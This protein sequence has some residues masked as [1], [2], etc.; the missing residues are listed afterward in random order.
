MKITFFSNFLNHHQTPFCDEMRKQLG[1]NFIFVSTEET[2]ED[3]LK[4]GYPDCRS[5]KYNLLAYKNR[6]NWKKALALGLN[7]DVVIAGSAP[8]IFIAERIKENKLTFR[9]S[10][11]IFKKGWWQ[12]FDIRIIFFLFKNH[13]LNRNKN[14]YMLC[15]SA[16]T[17][18]DFDFVFAY[19]AKK[20][21]WG[22]FTEVNELDIEI[23]IKNKPTKVLNLLW[24]GRFIDWKHP[25]LAVKLAV[26]LKEKGFR[27]HLN[28]IGNG[29]LLPQ[30]KNLITKSGL[31]NNI[32]LLGNMPNSEVRDYMLNS[33][34]FLFTSD[35]NEGWGA[36][37]NEAMSCGCTVVASDKIGAVPFLVKNNQNG[38]YFRSNNLNDLYEK[39]ESVIDNVELRHELGKNAYFTMLKQWSPQVATQNLLTTIDSLL[40]NNKNEIIDGP[41]SVATKLNRIR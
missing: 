23:V 8:D 38:I 14:I 6:E 1:D 34:I 3:F 27:F 32:T 24:V 9:Y 5:Y 30:I 25:E 18:N 40:Q 12:Y 17:A 13:T 26:K 19:P 22:Y 11:R 21:K 15:A 31:E 35:Q 20:F 36:V 37:L 29:E 28:M 33:N 16:F 2:P 41:C 10:E 39:V 4:S 7:S